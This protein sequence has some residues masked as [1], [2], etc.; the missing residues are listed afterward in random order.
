[1]IMAALTLT[2]LLSLHF[3]VREAEASRLVVAK[4]TAS[5]TS[6]WQILKNLREKEK[7]HFQKMKNS[8]RRVPS[9]P[10]NPKNN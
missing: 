10:S 7:N 5:T 1:M 8:L 4:K 6:S 2:L 9:G 3:V